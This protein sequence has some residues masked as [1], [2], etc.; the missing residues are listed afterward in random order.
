MKLTRKERFEAKNE[1]QKKRDKIFNRFME[2]NYPIAFRINESG[3]RIE[4]K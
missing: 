1:K 2:E 3:Y 4:K